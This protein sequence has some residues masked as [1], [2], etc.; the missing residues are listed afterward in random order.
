ME[1]KELI[2]SLTTEQI[3]D[4]LVNEFGSNEPKIISKALAFS[5]ICHNLPSDSN[6]YKLYYYEETKSFR[7]YTQCQESFDVISL[8]MKVK[9]IDFK[10]AMNFLCNRFGFNTSTVR[11]VVG[12]HEE[13][14]DNEYLSKYINKKKDIVKEE[15]TVYDK[16]V[17]RVFHENLF[18][19]GW[20][21]EGISIDVMRKFGIRYD[22]IENR[23]IIPHLNPV[24]ELIGI[25]T[26]YVNR[27]DLKYVPLHFDGVTYKYQT[28]HNLYGLY[29]NYK[30]IMNNRKVVIFES[31]KSVLMASSIYGDNNFCLALCGS[32]L[33]QEQV[34]LLLKLNINE[35]IIAVDKEYTNP[36]E[37]V[38][39]AEKIKKVFIKKLISFFTVSVI[40]DT[41]DKIGYKN[42]PID[43]GRE[44]FEYLFEN[45]IRIKEVI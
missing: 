28:G 35:V 7:C 34:Q 1:A 5:T 25:K 38:I 13:F 45:R 14:K 21:N 6:S 9:D 44:T 37:A 39:Y 41:E 2:N 30:A 8:T 29:Y 20:I 17:L 40:W 12:F 10:E 3:I 33:T 19:T 23:V 32:N 42:S 15:L 27:D 31:E 26:R 16:N 18:Y 22:S 24:G 36:E 11:R 4:L 43:C